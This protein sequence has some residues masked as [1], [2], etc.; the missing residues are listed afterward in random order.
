M[1]KY[2]RFLF[3]T[4]IFLLGT[5]VPA[6][7]QDDP[8]QR[9]HAPIP[10]LSASETKFEEIR[11]LLENK[12][13]RKAFQKFG[14]FKNAL[15]GEVIQ[16]KNHPGLFQSFYLQSRDLLQSIP[17]EGR[18]MYRQM[19]DTK[20]RTK[21]NNNRPLNSS[22]ELIE[23]VR[24]Y[25]IS[26]SAANILFELGKRAVKKANFRKART[27][28]KQHARIEYREPKQK[29][30]RSWRLWI[31]AQMGKPAQLKELWK[32]LTDYREE[33]LLF[34]G[35]R[36]TVPDLYEK[37]LRTA[38]QQRKKRQN[39]IHN[40]N[41]ATWPLPGGNAKNSRLQGPPISLNLPAVDGSFSKGGSKIPTKTFYLNQRSM[42]FFYPI[43]PV[44]SKQKFI[45]HNGRRVFAYN[46]PISGK[47]KSQSRENLLKPSWQFSSSSY[48]SKEIL[49]E[50]RIIHTGAAG[51]GKYFANLV[52]DIGRSETQLF[53]LH[54][55]FPIPRRTLFALDLESGEILWKRGG[56]YETDSFF[57]HGN[58]STG[59]VLKDGVLY[60]SMKKTESSVDTPSFYLIALDPDTGKLLWKTF[61]TKSG[62][63]SNLFGN[64]I[65]E[66]IS[67]VPAVDE[68]HIYLSTNV[69]VI[70]AADRT[71]GKLSW[72]YRYKQYP[73]P[74]RRGLRPVRQELYWKNNLPIRLENALIV[75]P[76][77][78]PYLYAFDPTSGKILWKQSYDSLQ[79]QLGQNP[80]WVV[81][82]DDNRYLIAGEKGARI[83]SA[84]QYGTPVSP[85]YQ[86]EGR[87]FGRPAVTKEVVYFSTTKGIE[88]VHYSEQTE[89]RITWN[90]QEKRPWTNAQK[91]GNLFN[92][93]G[94][95]SVMSSDHFSIFYNRDRMKKI[96]SQVRPFPL[97]FILNDTNSGTN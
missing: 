68:Q 41:P 39:G 2:P 87:H 81:P 80:R 55:R 10:R 85:R 38:H 5:L 20:A 34:R 47:E 30:N 15:E 96:L 6:Y 27:Y 33:E 91:P 22:E 46:L 54:V 14:E 28:F 64:P 75:T 50:D 51:D 86:S 82:V 74:P 45:F 71:S 88:K 1:T 44:L 69:G 66:N 53:D 61:V 36:T 77:N 29:M 58:F 62:I 89:G 84:S 19:Y 95:I 65:R 67:S 78:S 76:T 63:G 24:D 92:F 8:Y 35:N 49:A 13:Y 11:A 52:S 60:T 72:I 83:Y 12:Q 79:H 56:K 70:A 9:S 4:A 3:L 17:K 97:Q 26:T 31:L 37:L 73:T 59:P 21:R 7:S 42:N 18:E 43:F 93:G 23:I 25:P 16:S 48:S 94:M 57:R 32:Q 90:R 40:K